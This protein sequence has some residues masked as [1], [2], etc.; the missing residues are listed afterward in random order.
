MLGQPQ[1][2]YTS[3]TLHEQVAVI[4]ARMHMLMQGADN[5]IAQHVDSWA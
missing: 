2:L 5:P 4:V 3:I 1:L